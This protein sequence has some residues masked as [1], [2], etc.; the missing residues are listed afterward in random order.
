MSE[1]LGLFAIGS[2]IPFVVLILVIYAVFYV[3]MKF[4]TVNEFSNE[5]V[6][7]PEVINKVPNE[8]TVKYAYSFAKTNQF[9]LTNSRIVFFFES[10]L[11]G[12]YY[13]KYFQIESV[14]NTEIVYK[15][16]YVW[17]IVAGIH[18]LFGFISAI[19]SCSTKSSNNYFRDSSN[20]N[21]NAAFV[22][23][24]VTLVFTG[25]FCLVWYYLKGYYLIF[26]NSR[27]AGLFC[28]SREGLVDV[29]RKFDYLKLNKTKNLPPELKPVPT[30]SKDIIC[31]S[32]KSVITLEKDDL[33]S[34]TFVCPIC[35]TVNLTN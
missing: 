20:S 12:R 30:S 5:N 16:P 33:I 6:N 10:I 8:T 28:R 17:L 32:C 21:A 25:I 23:I 27:V 7:L 18:F 19:S 9:F 2:M 35:S 29:L 34:E 14:K 4:I 24:L 15:N 22:M 3:R 1:L 11:R 26:D 31:T 13:T